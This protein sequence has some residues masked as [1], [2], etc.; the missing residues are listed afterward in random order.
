MTT[1]PSSYQPGTKLFAAQLN[2]SFDGKAD[3]D[4]TGK[5]AISELPTAAAEAVAQMALIGQP[6]GPAGPLGSDGKLPAEQ[7]GGGGSGGAAAL[8][9]AYVVFQGY[10]TTASGDYAGPGPVILE[11]KLVSSVDSLADGS[12]QINWPGTS[13]PMLVSAF[14]KFDQAAGDTSIAIISEPRRLLPLGASTS[15]GPTSGPGFLKV[16]SSY[17]GGSP[18]TSFNIVLYRIGIVFAP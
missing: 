11:S 4:D 1:Q 12:W 5:L 18:S 6:G 8:Y 17:Q 3:L 7:G 2:T 16:I 15:S 13:A 9:D 10:A 14:G